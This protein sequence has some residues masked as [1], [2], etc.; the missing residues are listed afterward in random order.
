MASFQPQDV[1][2]NA[3]RVFS[4]LARCGSFRQAAAELQVSQPAISRQLNNLEQQLGVQLVQRDN[5][6]HALTPAGTQLAGTL[7]QA[8]RQLDQALVQTRQQS[9]Y[10]RRVVR[11]ALADELLSYWLGPQLKQFQELYPHLQLECLSAPETA[12][13]VNQQELSQYLLQHQCDVLLSFGAPSHQ[14]LSCHPLRRCQLV[15]VSAVDGLDQQRPL[16]SEALA[17]EVA[18]H[19]EVQRCRRT[20]MAI[21]QCRFN[22][23]QA[24]VPDLYVPALKQEGCQQ[25]A[26]MPLTAP[27]LTAVTRRQ[28]RPEL[29]VV[30]LLNWLQYVATPA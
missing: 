19:R 3:L 11:L 20:A 24:M 16:V 13:P 10:T 25:Q 6:M 18:N 5:R 9:Q 23:R 7:Q 15:L 8:F 30:A 14:Q 21:S 12:T 26:I 17:Q 2:L 1:S 28:S 29:A 27:E 4:T 22:Q